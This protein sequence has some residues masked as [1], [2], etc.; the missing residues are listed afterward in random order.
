MEFHEFQDT[1]VNMRGWHDLNVR[2]R[3]A[4]MVHHMGLHS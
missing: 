4:S 2:I 1:L 3:R